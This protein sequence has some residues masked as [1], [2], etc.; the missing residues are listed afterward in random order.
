MKKRLFLWVVI[1]GLTGAAHSS[2]T[3]RE[4][5]PTS[6]SLVKAVMCENIVDFQPEN[7]SIVFSISIGK[8]FC[9]T[10]F[11]QVPHEMPIYH[12]WYRKDQL[13]TKKKRMLKPPQWGTISEIQLR[14]TDKGPWRVEITDGNGNILGILRFSITD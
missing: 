13:S 3:E 6:L 7:I 2:A 5:T 1:L 4:P 12:Y 8:V 9:F 10:F 11:D 14:E